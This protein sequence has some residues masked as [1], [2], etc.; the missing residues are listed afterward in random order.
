MRGADDAARRNGP[1]GPN[2]RVAPHVG[3]VPA[4]PAPV[5]HDEAE[6]ERRLHMGIVGRA[7]LVGPAFMVAVLLPRIAPVDWTAG[8]VALGLFVAVSLMSWWTIVRHHGRTHPLVHIATDLMTTLAVGAT[9]VASQDPGT[10]ASL[11]FLI[12]MVSQAAI[13]RS[14][15]HL[16]TTWVAGCAAYVGAAAILGVPGDH[17]LTRTLLFASATGVTVATV[18]FLVEQVYETKDRA[19]D[20]RDLARIAA[21]ARELEV[22][23][24]A[25]TTI[26]CRLAE[27]ATLHLRWDANDEE[28]IDLPARVVLPLGVSRRGP[29]SLVL[30]GVRRPTA[31]GPLVHLLGQLC[32]RDRFVGELLRSSHTD[33]LTGLANRRA[34][35][36]VLDELPA[37]HRRTVVMIDL[38]HFKQLNDERGHLAG[39]EVLH[40]FATILEE[41][42]RPGDTVSRFGG[43]EFCLLLDADAIDAHQVVE[44]IRTAWAAIEPSVTFSAGIADDRSSD[45][46]SSEVGG[47]TPTDLSRRRV[48]DLVARADAALYRAKDGGR[49]RIAVA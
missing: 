3:P 20:L 45:E 33:P 39:D 4:D 6:T 34:L 10:T 29:V 37:D 7:L 40:R 27:A 25:A 35:D 19:D 47:T 46:R 14:R 31:T 43:E 22:G 9:I 21:D 12:S 18:A 42:V 28:W 23:I 44:R 26:I 32:E 15:A 2:R 30:D 24:Q 49:D 38:D 17:I 5:M 11:A 48:D 16:A 13:R 1:N 41:H 8:A 36:R